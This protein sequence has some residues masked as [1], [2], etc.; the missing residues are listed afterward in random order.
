[1]PEK[2]C[3]DGFRNYGT[4][5]GVVIVPNK[6]IHPLNS[7]VRTSSALSLMEKKKDSEIVFKGERLI[8][9]R[10]FSFARGA[11]TRTTFSNGL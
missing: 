8:Q 6:E 2:I 10:L 9:G 11:N 7:T 5:R 3:K 4:H 1:M